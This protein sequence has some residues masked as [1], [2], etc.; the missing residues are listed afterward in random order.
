MIFNNDEINVKN[1]FYIPYNLLINRLKNYINNS[2]EA[3]NIKK[4]TNVNIKEQNTNIITDNNKEKLNNTFSNE[5]KSGG[6]KLN[7]LYALNNPKRIIISIL[8]VIV[9]SIGSIK[10]I[11]LYNSGFF[12]HT[13]EITVKKQVT[14][15]TIYTNT[16][17]FI[18]PKENITITDITV[19]NNS[20][21][22]VQFPKTILAFNTYKFIVPDSSDVN[23]VLIEL[24]TGRI[25]SYT[26]D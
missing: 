4:N 6:Y 22:N 18:T 2:N 12:I 21:V 23:R 26:F 9:L 24:D 20:S 8:I 1:F 15:T 16:T 17:V 11:K 25:V 3:Y 7:D 13:P 5:K 14:T 19:N 10:L